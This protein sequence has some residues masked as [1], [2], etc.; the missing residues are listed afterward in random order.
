MH[1]IRRSLKILIF[2]FDV[3]SETLEWRKL[4]PI[5]YLT[6]S[7][8][9]GSP[10]VHEVIGR[11]PTYL[12]FVFTETQNSNWNEKRKRSQ[13]R[14]IVVRSVHCCHSLRLRLFHNFLVEGNSKFKILNINPFDFIL[15]FLFYYWVSLYFLLISVFVIF[16]CLE[17]V[18]KVWFYFSCCL[19]TVLC[20]F[21]VWIFA[22]VC[23]HTTAAKRRKLKRISN[24]WLPKHEE[25]DDGNIYFFL[26]NR[27]YTDA[28]DI[29]FR[30][31]F[32]NFDPDTNL[33]VG[34]SFFDI[35]SISPYAFVGW[36]ILIFL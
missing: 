20:V 16:N 4:F 36:E 13:E 12:S 34:I 18:V 28:R 26:K 6:T 11:S 27:G 1:D 15:N 29:L 17:C 5:L 10:D 30:Q 21:V 31:I 24:Q 22:Y 23:L 33:C 8:I 35:F 2:F 7:G 14:E 3:V 32:L 25:D 19:L 9:G